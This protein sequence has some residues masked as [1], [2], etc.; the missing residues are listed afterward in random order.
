MEINLNSAS[1]K[2]LVIDTFVFKSYFVA[3]LALM[4]IRTLRV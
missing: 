2:T 4:M 1:L 3:V